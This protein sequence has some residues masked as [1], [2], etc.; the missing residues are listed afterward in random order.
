MATLEKFSE[1][2]FIQWLEN[3][4]Y[5]ERTK[6]EYLIYY[7]KLKVFADL[8]QGSADM[9]C[10]SHE[11]NRVARSFLKTFI[12]FMLRNPMANLLTEPEV[13]LLRGIDIP[14]LKKQERKE[15]QVISKDEV[16][17]I[18]NCCRSEASKLMVLIAYNCG[19]RVSELCSIKIHDFNWE[20]W[21]IDKT[22][23]GRLTLIGKGEKTSVLPVKPEIMQRLG[24]W[25]NNDWG[26][27]YGSLKE[28]PQETIL[29]PVSVRKFHKLLA[30]ASEK[31]LGK[32]INPHR[33][34]HSFATNLLEHNIDIKTIQRLMRHKDISST[35]IYLHV[36]N[37][38]LDEA[39][40]KF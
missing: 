16:F 12:Q 23:M 2:H 1:T 39:I 10:Q 3:K 36:D 14:L 34:R 9:F 27:I 18:E 20:E 22:K 32:R 6:K 19:L 17:R 28:I 4:G 35:Q 26:K 21:K 11:G 33:L 15:P 24:E 29:F 7:K 5:T 31:A 40:E 37:K 30:N 8:N 13:N 38:R 25:V